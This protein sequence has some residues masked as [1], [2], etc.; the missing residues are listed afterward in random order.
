LSQQPGT[1]IYA[2]G[3]TGG[4]LLPGLAV[5]EEIRQRRP[6]LRQVFLAGRRET[7]RK[8][9]T[10]FGCEVLDLHAPQGP[11]HVW[12][13][14]MFLVRFGLAY[15]RC[16]RLL[17]K[18][19]VK[20]VIGLGGYGSVPVVLAAAGRC[21]TALL[22]QNVMAGR[23]NRLLSRFADAVVVAWE[24]S[25]EDFRRGVEIHHLGNPVRRDIGQV[26]REEAL[27]KLRLEPGRQTVLVWGGSQGAQAINKAVVA[28]LAGLEGKKG[29]PQFIHQT[30]EEDEGTIK[31]SYEKAGVKAHV[32]AFMH[33]PT[34]YAAADVFV[35]RAGATTL[36]EICVVGLP[37]ILIPYPH[38]AADHQ[39]ANAVVLEA[40][41]AAVVVRQKDLTGEGLAE[42]LEELL[43]DVEKR[44]EM[45]R[46]ARSL[47]RPSAAGDV[48]EMILQRMGIRDGNQ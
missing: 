44:K 7:E 22:E 31:A 4:H 42:T 14:P 20:A 10:N 35:G 47:A 46:C 39:S 24:S 40:S 28:G 1:I 16:K 43:G 17:R 21:V 3:G 26:K 19:N 32:A 45:S 5:A 12:E 37:M 2:G 11:A 29:T 34:A 23:A 38:A 27:E 30:G 18:N 6:D 13:Y 9:L 48:A 41:G 33:A 36:A 8:I 25:R 15:R